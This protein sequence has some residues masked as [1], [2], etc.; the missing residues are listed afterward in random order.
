MRRKGEPGEGTLDMPNGELIPSRSRQLNPQS[1]LASSPPRLI[2]P[3][4]DRLIAPSPHR[5][6]QQ[7]MRL[8][9]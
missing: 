7:R 5:R 6:A 4:P 9:G 3:S 8:N 2:A 1:S